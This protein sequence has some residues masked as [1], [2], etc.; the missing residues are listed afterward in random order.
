MQTLS[1]EQA[2][3]VCCDSASKGV[4]ALPTGM[5]HA[6]GVEAAKRL[7]PPGASAPRYTPKAG[8]MNLD[9]T[10]ENGNPHCASLFKSCA[11]EKSLRGSGAQGAT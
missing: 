7:A 4:R 9:G 3:T 8:S 1:T 5:N 6:S 11:C 10:A 2:V